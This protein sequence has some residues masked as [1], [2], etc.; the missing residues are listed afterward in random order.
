MLV[1]HPVLVC[2]YVS[3]D[4]VHR[5]VF[6]LAPDERDLTISQ[7]RSRA[8][9]RLQDLEAPPHHR[10]QVYYDI[11]PPIYE[12]SRSASRSQMTE[13]AN[14]SVAVIEPTYA[15]RSQMPSR[16]RQRNLVP[17][18]PTNFPGPS[19]DVSRTQIQDSGRHS[20]GWPAAV[21]I[22][23]AERSRMP[24]R[25]NLDIPEDYLDGDG[26]LYLQ[27]AASFQGT[28]KAILRASVQSNKGSVTG[29]PHTTGAAP[30]TPVEKAAAQAIQHKELLLKIPKDK[31]FKVKMKAFGWAFHIPRLLYKDCYQRAQQRRALMLKEIATVFDSKF[32]V[33]VTQW[34]LPS[35]EPAIK[36]VRPP[37]RHVLTRVFIRSSQKRTI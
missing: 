26:N 5:V 4:Q 9:S 21:D 17:E 28:S 31:I 7:Q 30:K 25:V 29:G 12:A 6:Q 13:S 18:I 27:D 22:S 8:V 35:M 37:Q 15:Q 34:I 10:D 2:D 3:S 19:R 11:P 32:K 14:V 23:I 1:I 24:S 36:A 33:L 16:Q 20:K